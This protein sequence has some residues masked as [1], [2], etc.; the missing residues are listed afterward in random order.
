MMGF[1]ILDFRFADFGLMP[2]V[3]VSLEWS[4]DS[5]GSDQSIW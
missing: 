4:E 1:L 5:S 2:G 3:F